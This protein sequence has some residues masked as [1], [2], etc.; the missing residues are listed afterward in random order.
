MLQKAVGV[1]GWVGRPI[2][3]TALC[4]KTLQEPLLTK[5]LQVLSPSLGHFLSALPESPIPG[6]TLLLSTMQHTPDSTYI[7]VFPLHYIASK[8]IALL[9]YKRGHAP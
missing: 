1:P 2:I 5:F 7:V 3:T 8:S 4:E 6:V 9:I